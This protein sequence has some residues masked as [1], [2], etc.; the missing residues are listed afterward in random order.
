[1]RDAARRGNRG[2]SLCTLA[3]APTP[4]NAW[5]DRPNYPDFVL[6][7]QFRSCRKLRILM[8]TRAHAARCSGPTLAGPGYY[9]GAQGKMIRKVTAAYIEELDAR[10]SETE[11]RVAEQT[12]RV[13]MKRQ[14]GHSSEQ[15][16]SLLDNL[17][18]SLEALRRLREY[19]WQSLRE[20]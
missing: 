17:S 9:T 6:A 8:D 2:S 13:R 4:A 12:E 14:A 1:L 3:C 16:E 18:I 5:L 15:S 11:Q 10:I 7:E 20:N 19:S